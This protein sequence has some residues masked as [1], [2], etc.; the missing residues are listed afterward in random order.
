MTEEEKVILKF[1]CQHLPRSHNRA[2]AELSRSTELRKSQHRFGARTQDA[3]TI[4]LY[5][6]FVQEGKIRKSSG[7]FPHRYL[8]HSESRTYTSRQ[9]QNG[10]V[11]NLPRSNST[12]PFTTNLDA[13]NC[14]YW[15]V[16]LEDKEKK[17]WFRYLIDV[18]GRP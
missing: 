15:E 2:L 10:V 8:L 5:L 13:I 11:L 3:K 6:N 14:T 16:L 17:D 1:Y 9:L 12:A 7:K 18:T 4:S